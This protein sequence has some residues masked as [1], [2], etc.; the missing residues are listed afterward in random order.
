MM[1]DDDDFGEFEAAPSALAATSASTAA[2]ETGDSSLP[3][4]TPGLAAVDIVD[5]DFG[6]FSG[7]AVEEE[8][9]A[10][11]P[12][13]PVTAVARDEDSSTETA[14][15]SAVRQ[16]KG[17]ATY[18]YNNNNNN[19]SNNNNSNNNN[20]SS[21][22]AVI[23]SFEFSPE[24]FADALKVIKTKQHKGVLQISPSHASSNKP[25]C[26]RMHKYKI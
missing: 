23:P 18:S 22:M 13:T 17:P 1:D 3:S 10:L 21:G 11:T 14:L 24:G 26:V 15:P 16:E 6:N 12:A 2:D 7:V 20:I 5:E 9:A 19:N 25:I 8:A 4:L